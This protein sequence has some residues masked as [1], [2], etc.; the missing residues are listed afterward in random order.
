[1]KRFR[2]L[3]LGAI[4]SLAIAVIAN[5]LA[6]KYN[7]FLVNEAGLTF[8]NNYPLPL[9]SYT[10]D[11]LSFTSIASSV[12]FANSTFTD[13]QASTGS[14]T[15][16]TTTGLGSIAAFDSLTIVSTRPTTQDIQLTLNGVTIYNLST[17]FEDITTTATAINLK[18]LLAARFSNVSFSTSG[19]GAVVSATATVGGAGANNMLFVSNVSTNVISFATYVS[20]TPTSASSQFSGGQNSASL[21]IA[22]FNIPFTTTVGVGGSSTTA[23]SIVAGINGNANLNTIIIATNNTTSNVVI[24]TATQVGTIGNYATFSS[25]QAA[26]TLSAPFSIASNGSSTGTMTG[27]INASYTL[28]GGS[29]TIVNITNHR[30]TLALQV[31]YS[32]SSGTGI[33]G[34]T[35]GTTYFIIPVSPNSIGFATSAANARA[36]VFVVLTS[37]QNKTTQDLFALAPLAI[38]GTPSYKWQVSNDGI[39]WV[40]YTTTSGNVAVSSVT[41]SVFNSTGTANSWDFGAIQY[42]YIRLAVISPTAGAINL[43][44]VGNGKSFE[45]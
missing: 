14:I 33:T 32:T 31:L 41:L 1:M 25:T 16:T 34:L 18:N 42:A 30:Y 19:A 29:A 7:T 5:A 24:T 39:N 36:S 2:R 15:V 40:D 11:T 4:G 6:V 45:K 10:I 9:N 28:A 17:P 8:N 27:G 3:F 38:A 35:N 20:S 37:S 44:V 21:S 23:A 43:Q 13:G 12:T 26:L 22:G